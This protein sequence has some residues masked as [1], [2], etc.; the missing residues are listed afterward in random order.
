MLRTAT[1][2]AVPSTLG[3]PV[4][5]FWLYGFQIQS[6][7]AGYRLRFRVVKSRP[8][9]ARADRCRRKFLHYFPGGFRDETYLEWERSYKWETHERWEEALNRGEF[10]RLLKK[11]EYSEVAARAVRTEQR[12]RHSMIFSFEKMALRDA[13]KSAAGAKVFAEGS[14]SSCTERVRRKRGLTRGARQSPRCRGV[15]RAS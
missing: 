12:A 7:L 9:D 14:T 13:V 1:R 10:R 6:A 4:P 8:A 2:A 11:R 3:N 5:R 15:R